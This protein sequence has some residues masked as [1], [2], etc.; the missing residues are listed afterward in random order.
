MM[1]ILVPF[2]Q[3]LKPYSLDTVN[4]AYACTSMEAECIQPEQ[5]MSAEPEE[6]QGVTNQMQC[7]PEK[8]DSYMNA[9]HVGDSVPS[10]APSETIPTG[11][12]LSVKKKKM[13]K[14]GLGI[15]T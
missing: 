5:D 12:T 10:P 6:E 9:Q 3:Q 14:H 8:E 2:P 4:P 15:Y 1:M 7:L 11:W 13:Q